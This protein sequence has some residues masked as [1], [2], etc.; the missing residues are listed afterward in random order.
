MTQP[1]ACHYDPAQGGR[2]TREHRDDCTDPA[3]HRGCAPCTA[4]H[5]STC[6]RFHLDNVHPVT[7]DECVGKVR[8]DLTDIRW[9]CR[10]IPAQAAYGSPDGRR[11][12]AAPIPGGDPMVLMGPSVDPQLVIRG[13]TYADVHRRGDVVPPL[14]VLAV[15]EDKW[16]T[17]LHHDT[18]SRAT[19]TAATRYLEG[20]L[21]Y[22]AQQTNGPDWVE[23]TRAI[24][25]VRRH[26]E[27][28]LHD[29]QESERGVE[30][31][32][33]GARLV[34][35]FRQAHPCRHIEEAGRAG[36]QPHLY[37]TM[38][39]T[40]P[41]LGPDA[42]HSLCTGQGGIDDPRAGSSWECPGCRKDYTPGEYATAVKRSL[43]DQDDD[44]S[45]WTDITLAA[46][47]ATTLTGRHILATTVRKWMDR[48]QVASLCTW[49]PGQPWGQRLVYWPDV[50]DRALGIGT[51]TRRAS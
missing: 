21:T 3:G 35:R 2:V 24:A 6:G 19:I 44:G 4:P 30:C 42:D 12:A 23:F 14:A 11:L 13:R 1:P 46:A 38:L 10:R 31:F 50:A 20:Q 34:R 25:D 26:L 29:E 18:T 37:V 40:Y 32:E 49:H 36:V 27:Y 5:C 33:C 47:A 51:G 8:E 28:T 17:W 7:C 22:M 16:R 43:L 39:A 45:G 41:E 9:L 15:W 48:G